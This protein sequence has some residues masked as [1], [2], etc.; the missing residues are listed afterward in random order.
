MHEILHIITDPAPT[1]IPKTISVS[2]EIDFEKQ[3]PEYFFRCDFDMA[4]EPLLYKVYWYVNS[5]K[6]RDTGFMHKDKIPTKGY[7]LERH[8]L[9]KHYRLNIM[10]FGNILLIT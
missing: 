10:V 6:I 1:W 7:L 9:T 4:T 3:P 2:T 8:L 5:K